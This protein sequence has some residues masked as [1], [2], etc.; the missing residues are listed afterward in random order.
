MHLINIVR[1]HHSRTTI[2]VLLP[3]FKSCTQLAFASAEYSQG[4]PFVS[5]KSPISSKRE[6]QEKSHL[7]VSLRG[8][9]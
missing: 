5:P 1:K 6:V 8:P 2:F 9:A 3:A 4:I 7:E